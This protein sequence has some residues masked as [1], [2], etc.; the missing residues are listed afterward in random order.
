M[1]WPGYGGYAFLSPDTYPVKDV[2]KAVRAG[3]I[4]AEQQDTGIR[5]EQGPQ[6]VIV[7]LPWAEWGWSL[8]SGSWPLSALP[9]CQEVTPS[10]GELLGTGPS[11]LP[12]SLAQIWL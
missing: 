9:Q 1:E 3:D 11:F 2:V 6:A 8:P 12:Q 10:D 4:K 7:V 5:V